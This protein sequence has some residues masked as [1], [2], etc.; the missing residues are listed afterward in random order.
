MIR[1]HVVGSGSK[2]NCYLLEDNDHYLALDAGCPWLDVEKACNFQVSKIDG[3][4]ITHRHSDHSN[5]AECFFCEGIQPYSNDD[6]HDF[7]LGTHGKYVKALARN[8]FLIIQKRW[9]VIPWEVPHS[10]R[11]GGRVPCFAYYIETPSGH[12]MAYIT[13]FLYSPTVFSNLKVHTILVACN[14]DDEVTEEE[15]G[16]GKYRHIVTGHSSLSVVKDLVLANQTDELRN[17]ILCHLSE[18]NA[19]P[20]KM[21]SVIQEA[22]GNEV[23]VTIARKGKTINLTQRE[24]NQ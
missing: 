21:Q 23:L 14:H 10:D 9:R 20:D 22:V 18:S 5:Y 8:S 19:S 7:I 6:T 24:V 3:C 17:V 13:D 15:N 4:L 11:N 2:G 16:E 1:L 12:R